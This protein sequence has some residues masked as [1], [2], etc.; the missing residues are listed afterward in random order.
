LIIQYLPGA[1][2]VSDKD[3]VTESS[4]GWHDSEE[5]VEREVYD[6]ITLDFKA[7]PFPS[8]YTTYLTASYKRIM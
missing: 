6:Q 1:F 4:I 8:F 3:P 2:A 7:I 5:S